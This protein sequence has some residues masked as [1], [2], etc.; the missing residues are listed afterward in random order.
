MPATGRFYVC[1]RCRVQV[2]VCRRCDRGQIYCDGDCAL[3]ARQSSVREAARRYQRSRNGRLAHAER[4]RRYRTRLN[5][6]THQGSA[7]AAA[8]AL[9]QAPPTTSAKAT[10][11]GIARR[12][13]AH[14]H[15]CHR[16]CSALVRLG[17]LRTRV[18]QHVRT[19]IDLT[20]HDP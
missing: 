18:F 3:A 11:P 15:F 6:V 14:C 13:P 8:D 16:A 1:A 10:T 7:A 12:L 5:K 20:G 17:P 9:L 2:I 19:A 4:M